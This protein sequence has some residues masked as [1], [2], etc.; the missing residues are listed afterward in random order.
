VFEKT[1]SHD[2]LEK[3]VWDI[4]RE[5]VAKNKKAYEIFVDCPLAR[6][7]RREIRSKNYEVRLIP[8][9][10][11]ADSIFFEDRF[12]LISYADTMQLLE[13]QNTIL[14]NLQRTMF[15]G[16]WKSLEK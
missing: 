15:E 5:I 10:T 6:T 8:K 14:T 4:G 13:V 16:L 7:Y 3:V 9:S 1:H 2:D 11:Q 12:F